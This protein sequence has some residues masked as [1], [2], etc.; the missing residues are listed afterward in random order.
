MFEINNISF[1]N[2]IF[3]LL[4]KIDLCNILWHVLNKWNLFF[5][6]LKPATLNTKCEIY[7]K[8]MHYVC[9]LI[10]FFFFFVFVI[11]MKVYCSLK[12]DI[13]DNEKGTKNCI[14]I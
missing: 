12:I 9:L 7:F 3:I 14:D 13:Y 4:K 10:I 6:I 1:Q 2:N 11:E 5:Y 8:I